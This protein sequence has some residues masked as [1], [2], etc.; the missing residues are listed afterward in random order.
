M[1]EGPLR[2][3]HRDPLMPT[4]YECPPRE[5]SE[6]D[7]LAWLK[8]TK[9][10]AEAW[11]QTQPTYKNFNEAI[12]I[13]NGD[14]DIDLPDGLS[15]VTAGEV[16]RNVKELT[17]TLSKLKAL[18]EV[19]TDNKPMFNQ[20]AI[21]NK[22]QD[23][24]W[25][26]TRPQRKIKGT[27]EFAGGAGTGFIVQEWDP[28]FHSRGRG[29]IALRA[30]GCHQ[31]LPVQ[32][33]ADHDFQ[34]AYAVHIV[35]EMTIGQAHDRWWAQRD[36]I[37]PDRMAPSWMKKGMDQVQKFLAPVLQLFGPG[38]K[39]PAADPIWP[40]VDIQFTYIKDLAI[41]QTGRTVTMGEPGTSWEY[42]V[43]SMGMEVESG[44]FQNGQ[45]LLRRVTV[46]EARLYPLRRLVIWC[47]TGILYDDTSYWWHG[48][49]PAIPISLDR[50]IW[51]PIGTPITRNV[52]PIEDEVTRIMR[53]IGDAA[54]TRLEPP[55][56]V[57]ENAFGE[58]D[59]Q[60]FSTRVPG[61]T[62]RMNVMMGDAVKPIL[63][64][65]F[66]N[67][68]N[69]MVDWVKFLEAK[70]QRNM[71]V[72]DATAI[73]TAK[74]VP[75]PD[76]V[77]KMREIAGPIL[78]GMTDAIE[79]ALQHVGRQWIWL[80]FQF[81]TV[82]RRI[83]LLGQDGVSVED[84]DYDPATLVPSHLPDEDPTKGPSKYSRLERA[85]W[86][87]AQFYFFV[88]PGSLHGI[89]TMVQRLLLIQLKKAGMWIDQ[90]TLAKAFNLPDFGPEP[91]GT[92]NMIERWQAEQ[93]IN[94]ENAGRLAEQTGKG[95][96]TGQ[97]KGGGRPNAN[98]AG[99]HVES[100]DA[101]TRSTVSTSR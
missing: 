47:E 68:P 24:W 46:E 80:A 12:A 30:Y 34:K 98:T 70:I 85:K 35:N 7:R 96:G 39:G 23:S 22:L 51:Q 90:W 64:P 38:V 49:F 1:R 54:V 57:N 78:T 76:T 5:A 87:A 94:Q 74:Q 6:T 66:Y 40:T 63:P 56:Q 28:N 37:T 58:D 2:V 65:E 93:R 81:Y 10:Q 48:E 59:A 88:V 21:L 61:R 52:A 15:R 84:Y 17:E 77:E 26:S 73:A 42:Q 43:P 36:K 67:L 41:N 99:P 8:Q 69:Y 50:F 71:G 100:K 95:Q 82:N 101:G 92:I 9:A 44:L 79:E 18:S 25:F 45:P 83:Q 86:H 13:L 53:A 97:G 31:V 16:R 60:E 27:L 91:E 19:R 89:T 62:Y 4:G 11:L 75:S 55:L 29:D 20:A 33:P 3:S 14:D 32:L 72:L